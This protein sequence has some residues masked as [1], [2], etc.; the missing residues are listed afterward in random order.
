M[1]QQ[2]PTD[3]FKAGESVT[4]QAGVNGFIVFTEEGEFIA[5]N[6][7]TMLGYVLAATTNH[8]EYVRQAQEQAARRQAQEQTE[9]TPAQ[10]APDGEA[11]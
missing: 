4:I 9:K 3:Y 8:A 10:D 11:A 7:Q 5:E 6:A 1:T 2:L